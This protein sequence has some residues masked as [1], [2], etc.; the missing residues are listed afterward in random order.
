MN[1]WLNMSRSEEEDGDEEYRQDLTKI[2]A[3][4]DI[5]KYN[6]NEEFEVES[7]EDIEDNL[8]E[9]IYIKYGISGDNSKFL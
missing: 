7:E 6:D 8:E 5:L 1:E 3:M 4:I 9:D 2:T